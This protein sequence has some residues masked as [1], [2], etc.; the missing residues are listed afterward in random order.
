V[1]I[2]LVDF[3]RDYSVVLC[4]SFSLENRETLLNIEH[5]RACLL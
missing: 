1:N 5:L 3:G 4:M 2:N